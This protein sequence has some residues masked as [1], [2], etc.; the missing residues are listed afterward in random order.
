VTCQQKLQCLAD[1]VPPYDLRWEGTFG[2]RFLAAE[3]E[4]SNKNYA[5]AAF[6]LEKA[7]AYLWGEWRPEGWNK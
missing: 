3:E 5:H 4:I 6:R 2:S 1:E 7:A